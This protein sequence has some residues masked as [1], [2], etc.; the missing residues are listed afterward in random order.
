MKRTLIAALTAITL[1]FTTVSCGK[2]TS[3]NEDTTSTKKTTASSSTNEE[4][5]K[6][7][8]KAMEDSVE[9]STIENQGDKTTSEDSS[10]ST[11]NLTVVQSSDDAG[12]TTYSSSSEVSTQSMDTP[13]QDTTVSQAPIAS[14][15]SQVNTSPNTSNDAPAIAEPT[16][17]PVITKT[18]TDGR[19]SGSAQGCNGTIAVSVTIS[20]DTITKIVIADHKD[21]EPFISNASAVINSIIATQSTS[22]DA[23]SGATLSSNGIINAVANA[24]ASAKN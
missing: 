14:T 23:V 18:Y 6:S 7:E 9:T 19:Y 8:D 1:I 10:T 2:T 13:A 22:V 20:D 17:E 21:D 3:K 24:L 16:P 15:N 12:T 4:A 5:E 11:D